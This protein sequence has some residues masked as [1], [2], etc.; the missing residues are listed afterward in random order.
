MKLKLEI[1]QVFGIVLNYEHLLARVFHLGEH[2]LFIFL[3]ICRPWKP[4]PL[5]KSNNLYELLA[6]ASTTVLAGALWRLFWILFLIDD[7]SWE[8]H[9]S[10]ELTAPNKSQNDLKVDRTSLFDLCKIGKRVLYQIIKFIGPLLVLLTTFLL[11]QSQSSQYLTAHS[12]RAFALQSQLAPHF[13]SY[14][15]QVRVQEPQEGRIKVL[16]NLRV[17]T[18]WRVYELGFGLPLIDLVITAFSLFEDQ[19]HGLVKDFERYELDSY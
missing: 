1:W 6:L 2:S 17:F 7:G 10:L 8:R 19:E 4:L 9:H 12:V 3:G 14:W 18:E 16:G 5:D 13:W 15:M 11:N